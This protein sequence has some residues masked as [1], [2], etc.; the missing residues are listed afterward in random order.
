MPMTGRYRHGE[1]GLVTIPLLVNLL[2]LLFR[3]RIGIAFGRMARAR[4][5]R[6]KKTHTVFQNQSGPHCF[7][8]I[9]ALALVL[10][11]FK[12][13]RSGPLIMA[14]APEPAQ[15][16]VPLQWACSGTGVR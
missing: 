14:K 10:P 11:L 12:V 4:K 2:V 3:S 16:E 13:D 7:W 6:E 15:T 8:N 5:K 1:I 9:S